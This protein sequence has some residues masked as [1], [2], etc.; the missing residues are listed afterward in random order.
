MSGPTRNL[1]FNTGNRHYLDFERAIQRERL[2]YHP[3]RRSQSQARRRRLTEY[4]RL[5]FRAREISAIQHHAL[6]V[7]LAT[8]TIQHNFAI[9]LSAA[10]PGLLYHIDRFMSSHPT[11]TKFNLGGYAVFRNNN[12]G[13]EFNARFLSKS[14]TIHGRQELIIRYEEAEENVLQSSKK[15]ARESSNVQLIRCNTV[16]VRLIEYQPFRG[17]CHIKLPGWVEGKHAC[18][19]I[20]NQDNL[21]F[22]HCLELHHR[23][24]TN[25]IPK[26][27]QRP[28]HYVHTNS[29]QYPLLMETLRVDQLCKEFEKLNP[30]IQLKIIGLQ[31]NKRAFTI[32]Y[33]SNYQPGK[34]C[35]NLLYIGK[36]EYKDGHFVYIKNLNRL[37]GESGRKRFF[38]ENCLN[39]FWSIDRLK[40]HQADFGCTDHDACTIELPY[41]DQA[42]YSFQ[43]ITARKKIDNVLYADFE[44]L[45][46]KPTQEEA[47]NGVESI[48]DP[49][50]WCIYWDTNLPVNQKLFTGRLGRDANT[51][52]E[53][54][55]HFYERLMKIREHIIEQT[56]AHGKLIPEYEETTHCKVCCLPL[57]NGKRFDFRSEED[58]TIEHG[59]YHQYCLEKIQPV[60]YNPETDSYD[61]KWEFKIPVVFHNLKN[62]DGHI[63]LRHLSDKIQNISCI[64]HNGEKF[65]TFSFSN[66]SFIDSLLFMSA[67]LDE[68][69]KKLKRNAFHHFESQFP[70]ICQHFCTEPTE[71]IFSLLLRKGIY[72]YEYMD[73]VERFE[74]TKI[75]P[76]EAFYSN[77]TRSELDEEDYHHALNIFESINLQNL[78]DYHDLYLLADV[79][80]LADVCSKFR[81]DSYTISGLDPFH[82]VSL[83]G[84]AKDVALRMQPN[85]L[86]GDIVRPFFIQVFNCHQMDM[87]LFVE[88]GIRGGLT[89]VPGRYA[90]KG[91]D[92]EI[93]YYDANGLYSYCMLQLLPMGDYEWLSQEVL[94]IFTEET[95]KNLDPHGN[96]GFLLEVDLHFPTSTHDFFRDIP[97]APT[98]MVITKDMLTDYQK[99]RLEGTIFTE[100]EKLCS[101]LWDRKNYIVDYRNLKLYLELGVKMTKVHRILRFSQGPWLRSFIEL[102]TQK[103]LE[104]KANGD[105]MLDLFFKLT[106]NCVY[107]KTME[108]A[109]RFR[110][111]RIVTNRNQM[112]KYSRNPLYETSQINTEESIMMEF[113]KEK[114]QMR[115][116]ILVG[117]VILELSKAHMI[118]FYYNVIKRT[119]QNNVRLLMTDT[120]SLVM[121]IRSPHGHFEALAKNGELSRHFD[122]SS[123]PKDHPYYSMENF[124]KPGY[125]KNETEG[126][127][128]HSFVGS[129]SK[130]YSIVGENGLAIRKAKG[131]NRNIMEQEE[132]MQHQRYV[133]CVLNNGRAEKVTILNFRSKNQQI[134]TIKTVKYNLTEVDS[135]LLT[136]N[137][138]DTIPHGHYSSLQLSSRCPIPIHV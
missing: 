52:K 96:K 137:G 100:T 85:M 44:C 32:I 113:R 83:P 16:F 125:F 70:T 35:V 14:F 60:K 80:L 25:N 6:E 8:R 106:M 54:I 129:S 90:I 84:F 40:Q 87:Q 17:G 76:K 53:L 18:I 71:D 120:D 136:Y 128:I 94:P 126:K 67:S 97:P 93:V 79:L 86:I 47:E 69:T 28:S 5:N 63:L 4:P 24:Y 77:L 7:Q 108:D 57:E 68:L 10:S 41:P 73:C 123:L 12:T 19:N 58:A 50:G 102:F 66:L 130:M 55:E 72:P 22:H 49:C 34:Q 9:L 33:K 95:I 89:L 115:T 11:G 74:E 30:Q 38:C 117:M 48:H 112:L 110:K 20:E 116:P 62:Y 99:K 135:K 114:V 127:A 51:V 26:N 37:L 2:A 98:K 15:I 31:S 61:V 91:P 121:Q 92:S 64:P 132:K 134:Q 101:P 13:D 131:I 23:H 119:F 81:S 21:C 56:I 46:R 43:K 36:E 65:M 27:P 59:S 103:R 138:V 88:R 118:G 133:D 104:A 42:I 124:Q 109:R 78:G 82:Y 75:P 29:Y 107:G 111:I 1:R 45:L 122:L 39:G 105:K 3:N